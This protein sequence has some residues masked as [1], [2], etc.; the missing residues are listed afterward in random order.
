MIRTPILAAALIAA[1]PAF[2]QSV[3]TS[4]AAKSMPSAATAPIKQATATTVMQIDVN[5]ATVDQLSSIKGLNRTLAEAI[6][7]GRPYKSLDE[8]TKNKALPED[9]FARVKGELTIHQR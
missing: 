7:K 1:A 5:T 6:V 8:L 3:A 4:P 2:A 9:V